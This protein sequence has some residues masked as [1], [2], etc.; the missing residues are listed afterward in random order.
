MSLDKKALK[1]LM[2]HHWAAGAGW[3]NRTTPE[4][5]SFEYAK[6]AGY[7]FGDLVTDHDTL[8]ENVIQ[9][10][11]QCDKKLLTEAF[12]ASLTTRRLDLRSALASYVV[13]SSFPQHRLDASPTD[14]SPDTGYVSCKI[15]GGGEIKHRTVVDLNVLSF[16]RFKWGGVRKLD[17]EYL[18]FDLAQFAKTEKITP[19]PED[20]AIFREIISIASNAPDDEKPSDLDKRLS[21][22]FKSNSDERRS[23]IET[24]GI[25]GILQ[26][27]GQ[28]SFFEGFVEIKRRKRTNDHRNDWG[29]PAMWWRGSDGVNDHALQHYFPDL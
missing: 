22:V 8:V 26:P 3:R 28:M 15:C 2:D 16:E 21:G 1:I 24:L 19:T 25:C 6:Q 9:V 17:P 12:L 4:G 29:Y 5:T 7:M 11:A 14:F 18:S 13:A 10:A 27:T 23:L 20:Y